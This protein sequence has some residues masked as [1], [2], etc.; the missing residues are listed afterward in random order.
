LAARPQDTGSGRDP[1]DASRGDGAS[2][3]AREAALAAL[4]DG[5]LYLESDSYAEAASSFRS[6]ETPEL[7][8]ELLDEERARLYMGIAR[9]YVGLGEH[10]VAR[11]Y[12]EKLDSLDVAEALDAEAGVLLARIEVRSGNFRKA[13]AAAQRAYSV[14][15]SRPDSAA[16]AEATKVLGTAHAELGDVRAARDCFIDCLVCNRRLGDEAGMAGA[17]NNLGI[18][19]KRSGD[20]SSA[21]E[22][23]EAALEIDERLGRTSSVAR[24]LDNLG[25]ALYRLSR[26][27]EAESCLRRSWEMYT[28]LGAT[29]DV[30]AVESA[31]GNLCRARRRWG[32]ARFYLKRVLET[33]R[34]AGYRRAE[35]LSLEFLGDLA[36]D[37]G[38]SDE[39]LELLDRA[40][41]CAR[42]LSSSSDV[43]S[44]VL[45]RR[46]EALLALGRVDEAERDCEQALELATR[47]GDRLEE[48]AILRVLAQAA[49]A[50]GD[51]A[52]ARTRSR[53]AEEILRTTGESFEL[54]RLALADGVGLTSAEG[55]ASETIEAVEARL[56]RAEELFSRI[57]CAYWVAMTRLERARALARSGETARARSWAERARRSFLEADERPG[58]SEVA[59][60]LESLDGELAGVAGE[61][62]GRY[63]LIADGYRRGEGSVASDELH[64][65]AE[66][67]ADA[68]AAD[69]VVL[70]SVDS[71]AASVVTSFDRT[72]RRIAEARRVV[73]AAISGSTLPRPLIAAGGA[74]GDLVP[75]G[76]RAVALIP[77]QLDCDRRYVLYVDR[78]GVAGSESFTAGDI[79]FVGAAARMLGTVHV[80]SQ[81]ESPSVSGDED[82][83]AVVRGGELVTRD[84]RMLR[85]LD[86]VSRLAVSTI[87]VLILGESGVGKDVVARAL[88]EG[89]S[90]RFVALNSGAIPPHL[91]ESELFGHVRGA[92]TDADRDRE[93][94][95]AAAAGGTLFLDE[96]GEMSPA[97]QVKL[98]RFLQEG[99]YRRVGENVPRASDARIVAASNRDLRSEA[100]AGRFRRDLFYRLSAFI[101]EVPPLRERPLDIPI[102]MEHFLDLYCGIEGKRAR[103]FTSDVREVFLAYDW[104]GNNIRELENEIRRG[105]ALCAEGGLIGIEDLRPELRARREA[106]LEAGGRH[107]RGDFV[108]L[109]DEV[110]ALERRR[111][112]EALEAVGHSKRAAARALGLSRTGLYSKLRKYGIE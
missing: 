88:H 7:L 93:G 56:Y 2:P 85:I 10:A 109:R 37:Q 81:R 101:I 112:D 5:A 47:L 45:R 72:G 23:F 90:G 63:A 30:V 71:G 62:P 66:R 15:R 9:C 3:S 1:F 86:D 41:E 31:L 87:P 42:G 39:A 75:D 91:Q 24:R 104:R 26:W 22:Y 97:L 106:I 43:V 11:T 95:I 28:R 110:E 50:C 55:A 36:N 54:A 92:F 52:G 59:A 13:L 70:F 105:V 25:I 77:A 12:L 18:L 4:R 74:G 19:A 53:R 20:L 21:V 49:Y 108:S 60:L 111:I 80:G 94:L 8:S 83:E 46:A 16:L 82:P 6:A 78:Q 38:R 100:R 27:D 57:G 73:R 102:L 29:R 89:R 14:L 61:T 33:S 34:R 107:G 17:Y 67:V 79:E 99:E 69:R 96:V 84:P 51:R 64:T 44:E 58:A 40:L 32:E 35:A 68:A 103:G 76:V 48:G 65:L 98:L